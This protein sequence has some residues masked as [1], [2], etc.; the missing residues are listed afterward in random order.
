VFAKISVGF[1]AKILDAGAIFAAFSGVALFICAGIG[2]ARA[3]FADVFVCT[4]ANFVAFTVGGLTDF[5]FIAGDIFAGIVFALSF[6]A[7]LTFGA[8]IDVASGCAAFAID[9]DSISGTLAIGFAGAFTVTLT[10]DTCLV[11]W[12]FDAVTR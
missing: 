7:D 1:K 4:L 9:A 11:G 3:I 12:T 6:D 2:F 5:A 8:G 10:I